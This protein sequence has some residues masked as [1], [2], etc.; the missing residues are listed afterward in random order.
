[1]KL[2]R[3][4]RFYNKADLKEYRASFYQERRKLIPKNLG[5]LLDSLGVAVWFMD[6]GGRGARTPR[7]LVFN[8]SCFTAAEQVVLQSVLADTFGMRT[9]IHQVGKGFQLYV[10]AGS[11]ARFTVLVAPHLITRLR[12]KLPLY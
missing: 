5:D 1:M 3:S 8:T 4:V 11:I 12:Y 9:S 2:Y 6:D 10:R 7:G